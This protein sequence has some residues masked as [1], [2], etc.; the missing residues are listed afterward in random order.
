LRSIWMHFTYTS[1][2]SGPRNITRWYPGR[3]L[4]EIPQ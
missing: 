1:Q 2:Q 4:S 3:I